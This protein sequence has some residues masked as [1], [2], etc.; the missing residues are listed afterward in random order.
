MSMKNPLTPAGIEPATFRSVAQH[1]N[2]CATAVPSKALYT[3][4]LNFCL[5]PWWDVNSVLYVPPEKTL[6]YC[7]VKDMRLPC[8]RAAFSNPNSVTSEVPLELQCDNAEALDLAGT[9]CN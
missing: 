4:K 3:I 2:H 5:G 7:N 1:L 6:N 8:G 9:P